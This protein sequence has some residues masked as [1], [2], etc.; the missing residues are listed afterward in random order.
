MAPKSFNPKTQTYT[1][2]RPPVPFPIDPN[3]SL[4]SFLFQSS[5][6]FPN[7]LALADAD[8][9][10]TLTFLQLKSLVFKL[11]HALLNHNIKKETSS[12]SSP[13]TPSTSRFFSI[14]AITA[15]ATNCNL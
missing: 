9:A 10:K 5:T 13:K 15:I 8:I 3:L 1:S 4:T 12:S 7:N 2:P 11:A 14:V 6:S